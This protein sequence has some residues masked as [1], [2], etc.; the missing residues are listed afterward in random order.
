MSYDNSKYIV[1]KDQV[2]ESRIAHGDE[3]IGTIKA[4][5]GLFWAFGQHSKG[6]YIFSDGFGRSP[7]KAKLIELNAC[8]EIFNA[9]SK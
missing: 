1:G 7:N 4:K 8:L 6:H 5:D 2:I 9:N 3:H